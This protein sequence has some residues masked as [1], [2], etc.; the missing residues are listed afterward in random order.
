VTGPTGA[1]GPAG[2]GSYAA[3][4]TF[5]SQSGVTTGKCLYYAD[6]AGPGNGSCPL[7]TTGYSA[8]DEL[9]GPTPATGATVTA[10]FADTNAVLTGSETAVVSVID[11]T[12]GATLL[13][14]T[15]TVSSK[16]SCSSLASNTA[17]AGSNIEVKI[18]SSGVGC[19][20]KAWRVRFR[21]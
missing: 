11:N 3:V 20:D 16:D 1:T 18:T 13:S 8:S 6:L 9:M 21:Y 17:A 7:G 4:A 5:A 2:S 19:S 15:V 10:L 12:T 14:C